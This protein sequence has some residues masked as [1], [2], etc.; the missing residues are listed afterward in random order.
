MKNISIY[1]LPAL[2]LCWLARRWRYVFWGFMN[3]LA[4]GRFRRIG[5]GVKFNGWVRVE[6]PCA[7]IQL[8]DSTM[9][10]VGCYFLATPSGGIHIGE[11]VGIN[12]YCYITSNYSIKIGAKVHIAEHVSIR[13]YD[14]EFSNPDV[15]I[16]SQGFRGGPVEIG[17]GSWI[18]RGVM[19]TSKVRIGQGCIIGANSVVT[20]DIPAF[21]VAVGA[22][23]RVIKMR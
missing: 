21:S 10:G 1:Q 16:A 12:D 18:G 14:H 5:R 11:D 4:F 19:I 2:G 3:R 6:K 7:D 22:P 8:G 15:P 13:D 20:K 17:A 9:V 23:A